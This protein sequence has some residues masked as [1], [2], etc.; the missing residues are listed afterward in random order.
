MKTYLFQTGEENLLKYLLYDFKINNREHCE[1]KKE[2]KM[3]KYFTQ[4]SLA[5]LK[6]GAQMYTYFILFF[7]E[8]HKNCISTKYIYCIFYEY[9]YLYTWIYLLTLYFLNH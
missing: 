9:A 3:H 5:V 6:F 8:G 7:N 4:L 1:V 2:K